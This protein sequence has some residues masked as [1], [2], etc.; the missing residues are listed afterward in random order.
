VDNV[1]DEIF[2]E[3]ARVQQRSGMH[4]GL[5][6][7][8]DRVSYIRVQVLACEDELHEALAEVNWKTWVSAP[9]GFKSRDKYAGELRD[10]LQFLVNL[11]IAAG[12]TSDELAEMLRA[13]WGVNHK[14]IDSGYDGSDKCDHCRRAL[15]EPGA[16][17]LRLTDGQGFT[18]CSGECMASFE[19]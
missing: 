10:A 12:V 18:F 1:L 4:P 13:K 3:Q 9:P 7:D 11:M 8:A 5:M 2:R 6:S 17:S 15:D 16:A 19:D 14:R